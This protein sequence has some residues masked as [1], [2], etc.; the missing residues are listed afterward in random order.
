MATAGTMTSGIFEL[1]LNAGPVAKFVLGVLLLFSVV[2]W[3]L[4]VEK[5]WQLRRVRRQ[6]LGFVKVFREGRRPSMVHAAARKFRES[7]LAQLYSAAYVEISGLPEGG[8]PVIDD[9]DEGRPGDHVASHDVVSEENM[10]GL[11]QIA[12]AHLQ[13]RGDMPELLPLHEIRSVV[14]EPPVL[15]EVIG[16]AELPDIGAV[17]AQGNEARPGAGH[18]GR[19]GT[20]PGGSQIHELAPA[21]KTATRSRLMRMK[22]KGLFKNE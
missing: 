8:D 17:V 9:G 21:R 6:T 12:A 7:P 16:A 3:A 22:E 10:D 4:I 1:V 20:M 19:G 15:T 13:H 2:S 5:W 14:Q 18:A 11:V